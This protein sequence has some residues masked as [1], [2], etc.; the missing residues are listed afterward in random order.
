MLEDNLK[1]QKYY[2][3]LCLELFIWNCLFETINLKLFSM[4]GCGD[5]G[6]H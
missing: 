5:K 6:V 3:G 2:F 4:E 1:F